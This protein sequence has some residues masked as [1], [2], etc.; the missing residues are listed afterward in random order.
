M[1]YRLLEDSGSLGIVNLVPILVTLA[2]V[3]GTMR[4]IDMPFNAMT[5]TVLSIALG[6]GTDYSAHMTHRFVDEFDGT[7]REGALEATVMGTGGALTGSMLT[8]ASGI[9]VLV[10]SITPILG[11]FGTIMAISIVY[12]YLTAMLVTPSAVVVWVRLGGFS[13]P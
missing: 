8:T 7:N 5:A 6:L 1:I 13:L 3:L 2:L 9:G 10:L 4:L 11:Q 12:S